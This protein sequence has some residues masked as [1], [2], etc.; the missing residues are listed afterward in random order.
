MSLPDTTPTR[1]Q[2]FSAAVRL[3]GMSIAEWC[4]LHEITYQH[5]NRVLSGERDASAELNAAIDATI[6][7]YLGVAPAAAVN[8]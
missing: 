7:K 2:R 3:S 8:E 5:V 1:K 6:E 4:A